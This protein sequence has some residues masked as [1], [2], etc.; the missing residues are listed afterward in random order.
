MSPERP[1]EESLRALLAERIVVIDGAMGTM[2]QL[3][4]LGEKD[5]RGERFADHPQD[6]KG[7]SDLQPMHG[8]AMVTVDDNPMIPVGEQ[9]ERMLQ[10]GLEYLRPVSG[11]VWRCKDSSR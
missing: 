2:L 7:N 4:K 10:A 3:E 1:S 9:L 11:E 8:E 5:F 6:V